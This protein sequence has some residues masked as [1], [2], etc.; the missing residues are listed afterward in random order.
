MNAPDTDLT[1]RLESSLK[2]ALGDASREALD[3]WERLARSDRVVVTFVGEYDTGKSTLLKRLLLDAG[4]EVP[5]W[6]TISA[7][8]ETFEACEVTWEALTL[9]DTPGLAGGDAVHEERTRAAL[10]CSDV[11]VVL[12][13]PQ[14]GLSDAVADLLRGTLFSPHGGALSPDAAVLVAARMDEAGT[15]PAVDPEGFVEL[16]GRKRTEFTRALAQRG[17]VPDRWR[18]HLVAADPFQL[19]GNRG[20]ALAEEFDPFRAWDGME[21]LVE[22]LRGFARQRERLRP[23][24][25][26]R[27][28]AALASE[29]RGTLLAAAEREVLV[30][31]GHRNDGERAR[32]ASERMRSFLEDAETE[33]QG[34]VEDE[35]LSATRTATGDPNELSH[36]LDARLSSALEAW[37]KRSNA[38]CDKL[39]RGLDVEFKT[40]A[41]ERPQMPPIGA[42][43]APEREARKG[44]AKTALP[45]W[46]AGAKV[47]GDAVSRMVEAAHLLH[48]GDTLK[49][50]RKE[51]QEIQKLQK[52]TGA[53]KSEA[54]EKFFGKASV[55]TGEKAAAVAK[56]YRFT[57]DALGVAIP[58]LVQFGALVADGYAAARVAAERAERRRALREQ[59][60]AAATRGVKRFFE[61]DTDAGVEGWRAGPDAARA[62]LDEQARRYLALA[63]ASDTASKTLRRHADRL[64]ELLREAARRAGGDSPSAIACGVSPT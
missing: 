61:G 32:L 23:A 58:A 63:S 7:R 57:H 12:L 29:A 35:L 59:I 49:V 3:P 22:T 42:P 52:L 31:D 64:D 60:A 15:D 18:L 40:A 19:V 39:V 43:L 44:G 27:F 1:N 10:R 26:V 6:L 2:E 46:G 25:H 14:V 24:A 5:G 54:L 62:S 37:E 16:L 47:V 8:R 51:L 56:R 17:L 53:A 20:D 34:L 41:R 45:S 50:S 55:V 48:L 33:L 36:Q 38:A 9:R 4:V 13:K 30:A 21:A 11:Y 28:L